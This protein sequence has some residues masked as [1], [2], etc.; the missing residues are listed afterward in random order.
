[1][2]LTVRSIEGIQPAAKDVVVWD[3]E[4]AGFGLKVTPAGKRTFLLFYRTRD[5]QQRK[6]SIG[7]WPAVRPEAARATARQW[8]SEVAKGSDPSALRQEGR[9]AP[10]IH[11]LCE[12][13]MLEHAG[14]RKKDSSIRN[15]RRLIDSHILPAIGSK[16]V[17]AVTR[18]HVS[19]LHHSISSTPYE[20]NRCL[21]LLSK[22][23]SLAER[24]GL[25][26]DHSNPAKNIDR[27]REEKRERFLTSDEVM[28]LWGVLHS[29]D[30]QAVP[31]SAIAAIKL[32]MLT[33]RRLGEVLAL[34]WAWINFNSKM[35]S[36]PDTK[37]GAFK[38]PLGDET[39]ALLTELKA[40][41]AADAVYVI[42]GRSGSK[43]LVNLQKPW[44]KIRDLAALDEVRLH[45]LR[46]T[47]ASVA[48]SLGLSLPMIGKLLGHTQA[49]TTAR[50][51]HLADDPVKLAANLVGGAFVKMT[52]Q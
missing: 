30:V 42:P 50:Y 11:D 16:K 43:P 6:P 21:A 40:S 23:F 38:V 35:L 52:S 32:L 9:A 18:A 13:Y 48:A 27:Y 29:P 49:A 7:S 10:T 33:G 20:A 3:N 34:E 44:R 37:T 36:L 5:G 1:M 4:I 39:L 22:M 2:K 46:H 24:W 15:D 17:A 14:I 26:P 41:P 8:L 31:T 19:A 28:R 47:Y 25:R 51:A 45:D 12:R